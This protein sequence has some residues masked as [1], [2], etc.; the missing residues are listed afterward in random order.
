MQENQEKTVVQELKEYVENQQGQEKL[1]VTQFEYRY[2][3]QWN[4]YTNLGE[5]FFEPYEK[6]ALGRALTNTTKN[7]VFYMGSF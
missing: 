1:L 7:V 2:V 6:I 5:S 3:H 4:E